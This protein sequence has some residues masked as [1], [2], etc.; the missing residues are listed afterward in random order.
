[1]STTLWIAI[2]ICIGWLALAIG[3]AWGWSS[4]RALSE[5]DHDAMLREL[6]AARTELA[7]WRDVA[8]RAV[9]AGEKALS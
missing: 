1:M 4:G 8:Y 2:G 6:I 3:Y 5:E 9:A 7:Q